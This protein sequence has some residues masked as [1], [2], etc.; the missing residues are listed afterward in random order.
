MNAFVR[1]KEEGGRSGGGRRGGKGGEGAGDADV[2]VVEH[3]ERR[4]EGELCRVIE[5]CFDQIREL[6]CLHV[7]LLL[8]HGLRSAVHAS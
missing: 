5:G 8:R 4:C 1:H 3:E 6:H 2:E 7:V